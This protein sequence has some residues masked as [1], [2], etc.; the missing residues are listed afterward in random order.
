MNFLNNFMAKA[1]ATTT[2]AAQSIENAAKSI[3]TDKIKWISIEKIVIDP[4]LKGI[5][6]QEE[7]EIVNI[8]EDMKINDYNPANPLTLGQDNVIV[9]GHTRYL[10]AL[11]AGLKKVAVIYKHFDSR[12]EMLSYAYAQQ[13]NRRNLSDS[14]IFL[15]YQKLK[16]LTDEN[17]K[18]A[19]TDVEI[20]EQL[21]ISPRQ[22]AKMKEVEKKAS[23]ETMDKIISGETTVNKVY[24][25]IKAS[26]KTI[27]QKDEVV[28]NEQEN[29]SVETKSKKI[30]KK[31]SNNPNFEKLC[32]K[33][34]TED[35]TLIQKA[36]EKDNLSISEYAT[37]ILLNTVYKS[38]V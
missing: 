8:S 1:K 27:V 10:A 30:S 13:L 36:A 32:L 24:N 7:K 19:K 5:Y 6:K 23:S 12:Q 21:Q 17:G 25:E 20:A 18:K 4:E 15:S 3:N 34:N 38:I 26:E 31:L 33:L 14:E 2:K 29:N 37:K 16:A 11:R 35:F 28:K 9:D 22:V